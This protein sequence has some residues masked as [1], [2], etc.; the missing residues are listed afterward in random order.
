MASYHISTMEQF[1]FSKP[2][3]WTQWIRRFEC[4]RQASGIAAKSEE[5]Q[6]NT[7]IY[8]MGQKAGDIL[9]SFKLSAEEK[10][11]ETVKEKF[12]G[13]FIQRCN[14]IFERARFNMQKQREN[15]SVDSFITDLYTLAKHCGYRGLHNKII[16]DRIVVGIRNSRVSQKMQMEADLMLKKAVSLA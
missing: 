8:S 11:Y 10:T 14:P 5:N 9:Q 7:L 15:E 2:E 16:R 4:F 12:E 13:Y 3:Q 1:D 6:V